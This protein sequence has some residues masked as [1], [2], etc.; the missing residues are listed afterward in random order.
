M[1]LVVEILTD[2]CSLRL[3]HSFVFD[4][5]PLVV[6][7][8]C[9]VFYFIIPVVYN[10]CTIDINLGKHSPDSETVG[11]DPSNA[12]ALT[13]HGHRQHGLEPGRRNRIRFQ[14]GHSEGQSHRNLIILSPR[15][16]D[17]LI[18]CRDRVAPA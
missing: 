3:A 7:R 14:G 4:R 11:K 17:C 8:H 6:V 15:D 5:Q 2:T 9:Y 12:P 13:Q 10:T 16:S 1:Y 18:L